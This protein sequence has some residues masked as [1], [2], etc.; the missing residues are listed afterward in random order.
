[1][2]K[3]ILKIEGELSKKEQVQKETLLPQAAINPLMG[4][5]MVK[6]KEK[7]W[8]GN[9]DLASEEQKKKM[10]LLEE[11]MK[12]AEDEIKRIKENFKFKEE[13]KKEPKR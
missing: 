6:E 3:K 7:L 4:R 11:R 13:E 9:L 5:I 8:E 10:K 2:G 12:E 1:M